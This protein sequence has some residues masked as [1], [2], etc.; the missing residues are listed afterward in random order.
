VRHLVLLLAL[1]P[2]GTLK[3]HSAEASEGFKRIVRTSHVDYYVAKGQRVDVRRTEAFLD[4]LSSL[5]GAAPESWR[6]SYYRHRSVGALSEH[7]GYAVSGL[8]DLTAGRIDS[9]W[10]FHPHELV[11]AVTGREGRPPVFFAEG[12]AVALTS[13]G[14]WAGRDMDEVAR[15][16]MA[17]RPGL[18]PFLVAFGEQNPNVAY[19]VAGSFV[20]F[21]LDEHGIGSMVAF[22]RGCDASATRYELAFRRAYGR[23]TARLTIEW[24]AWLRRGDVVPTRAWYEPERWP[25]GLQREATARPASPSLA[26]N[27]ERAAVATEPTL[28]LAPSS[29]L[30]SQVGGPLAVAGDVDLDGRVTDAPDRTGS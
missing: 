4:Q 20:A 23:S 9:A 16:E 13:R 28:T 12:I 25:A 17:A 2:L 21:L 24:M 27:A 5:F 1:G 18:E 29:R 7:V 11:H 30:A 8:A 14:R 22:V 15:R 3:A 26:A 19:A 10:D 6:I